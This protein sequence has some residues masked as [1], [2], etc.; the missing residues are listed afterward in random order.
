MPAAPVIDIRNLCKTYRGN[1][2]PAIDRLSLAIPRGAIFGLL[3]PNGAGKTTLIHI[4]CGLRSFDAGEVTVC[5]RSL[6]RQLKEIKPLIGVVPQ[7]IALFPSLTACENLNIFGRILGLRGETLKRR[8]DELLTLFGLEQHK[9]RRIGQY[10]G[11]MKR[12]INLIAG[13]LHNPEVLFLDEPTVGVDVQSKRLILENLNV[14]NRN[15]S[16]IIYT[17]HYLEEAEQLCS[18]VAF[19]DEGRLICRGAPAE[20]IRDAEGC[21]SLEAL[22]LQLTGKRVRD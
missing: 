17:S 3:G 2:A 6:R 4:L 20:L 7:D 18:Q 8:I 5:S 12:R 15:G 19:I 10:S 13:L 16:T 22:Y 11:G 14:V 9:H 1:D 21:A